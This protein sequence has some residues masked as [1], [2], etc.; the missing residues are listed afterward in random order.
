MLA[1][2]AH[3]LLWNLGAPDGYQLSD[4]QAE[5]VIVVLHWANDTTREK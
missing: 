4:E 5:R 1:D 3:T 2:Y